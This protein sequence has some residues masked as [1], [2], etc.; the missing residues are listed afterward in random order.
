MKRFAVIGLGNFGFYAA[1]SLFEDGH[2]VI[3]MDTNK[4]RVQAVAPHVTEAMVLDAAE[5]DALKPLGLKQMDAVIIATGT[6]IGTSILICL[7]LQEIGVKRILAKALHEDH[8]KILK[9]LGIEEIIHPERDMALRVS[10]SLS[11][12]NIIDFVPLSEDFDLIQVGPPGDFIGKS[13]K[14]LNLRARHNVHVIAVKELVPEK[15]VIVPSPDFIIKDSDILIM[16]GKNEDIQK[17]KAL[18]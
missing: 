16:L 1:K 3:A 12:P 8:E 17:I 11:R 15:T 10:R 4:T 2:E 14:E 7:H 5:K 18:T 13:L 6:R 9:R